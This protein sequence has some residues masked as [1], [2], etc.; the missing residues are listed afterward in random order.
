MGKNKVRLLVLLGSLVVLAGS[1]FADV[2]SNLIV[3]AGGYQWVWAAP[4][5][6]VQPSCGETL[7]LTD[8]W[9][10]PTASQ[11][12]NSFNDT[13]DVFNAFTLPNEGTL[14]AASY[15][16]SGYDFCDYWDLEDG[17]IWGAPVGIADDQDAAENPASEAFLVRAPTAPAV[18]EPSSVMLL[19][20]GAL[21]VVGSIRR[22][23]C[24]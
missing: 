16:N 7:S 9:S 17:Y 18:P 1:A 11:W 14:C 3:T 2:P 4:C 13:E 12:Q 20:S 22:K 23:F 8:G 21:A 5:A 15:F 6:P 10:I 19:G 24:L